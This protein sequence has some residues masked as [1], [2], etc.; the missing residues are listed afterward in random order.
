MTPAAGL[1]IG[2][3]LTQLSSWFDRS[4][5]APASKA[6]AWLLNPVKKFH[7]WIDR[8]VPDRDPRTRGWHEFVAAAGVGLVHQSAAQATYPV[9]TLSF[10]TSLLRAPGYGEPGRAMAQS[11]QPNSPWTSCPGL[12]AGWRDS[13]TSPTAKE[14]MTSPIFTAGR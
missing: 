8:A 3:A 10:G 6:M 1:A 4:S 5:D 14:R 11:C 13:A 12:K 2:E 7:D 9:V